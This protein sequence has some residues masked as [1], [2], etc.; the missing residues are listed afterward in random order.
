MENPPKVPVS[1]LN[2]LCSNGSLCNI[3]GVRLPLLAGKLMLGVAFV[4]GGDSSF[5]AAERVAPEEC[6]EQDRSPGDRTAPPA[7]LKVTGTASYNGVPWTVISIS[8]S[9]EVSGPG[10]LLTPR[11]K[12]IRD[13]NRSLT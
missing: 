6:E 8:V 3:S 11:S 1:E 13:G 4:G 9:V 2:I 5:N 7:K 12:T 10:R